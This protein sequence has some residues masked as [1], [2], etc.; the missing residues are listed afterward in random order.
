MVDPCRFLARARL[1]E[2]FESKTSRDKQVEPLIERPVKTRNL[3]RR[4]ALTRRL[5]RVAEKPLVYPALGVEK[6]VAHLKSEGATFFVA[7]DAAVRRIE[8]RV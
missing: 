7:A 8:A 6:V 1:R 2:M 5:S 4:Q 3:K